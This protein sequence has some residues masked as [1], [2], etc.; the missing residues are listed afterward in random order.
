VA[1]VEAAAAAEKMRLR[2]ATKQGEVSLRRLIT[3]NRD[4]M[5]ALENG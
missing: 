2:S 4:F 1:A 3:E 5:S